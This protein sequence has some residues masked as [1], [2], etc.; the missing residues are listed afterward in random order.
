MGKFT[1]VKCISHIHMISYWSISISNSKRQ[2]LKYIFITVFTLWNVHL[3]LITSCRNVSTKCRIHYPICGFNFT[4]CRL[5][6]IATCTSIHVTCI[7]IHSICV[8]LYAYA[9][10]CM[11]YNG[12]D[13]CTWATCSEKM[14]NCNNSAIV[15][16]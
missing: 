6:Y 16:S 15:A 3:L 4:S 9:V 7:S 1:L 2:F 12:T 8:S 5:K 13:N 11:N 14:E 10:W